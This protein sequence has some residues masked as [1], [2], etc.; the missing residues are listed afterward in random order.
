M[1]AL[2]VFA[3]SAGSVSV[4]AAGAYVSGL[5]VSKFRA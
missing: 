2:A 3:V 5:V 1:S 4:V